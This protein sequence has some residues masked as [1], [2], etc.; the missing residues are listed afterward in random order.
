MTARK[1][2]LNT[3]R[4]RAL[5]QLI[6]E[7]P[8]QSGPLG[9]RAGP[10]PRPGVNSTGTAK[11]TAASGGPG[12]HGRPKVV[13][14]GDDDKPTSRGVSPAGRAK[15]GTLDRLGSELSG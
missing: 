11:T 8:V 15:S 9:G 12:P 10:G 3:A 7:P 2:A 1:H 13:K 5:Q 6:A 4:M 14:P